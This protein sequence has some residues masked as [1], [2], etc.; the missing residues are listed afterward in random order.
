MTM[1]WTP[2]RAGQLAVP[3]PHHASR[4]ARAASW[5]MPRLRPITRRG[6]HGASGRA[7]RRVD[8]HGRHG[9]RRHDP[10]TARVTAPSARRDSRPPRKLT[11][12]IEK[13]ARRDRRAAG[14]GIRAER[15]RRPH[16]R[17]ALRSRPD[18]PSCCGAIE[19]VEITVVNHLTEAT[20]IH[21]H[22]MELDSYYDG[23]H[24]WSG[25]DRRL[26]P[27]IEPGGTFVVRFTPPR[28]GTFIYHTHLH[29]YRQLSSGLYG[30]IDRD[31]AGRD[32]RSSDR[33][34]DRARQERPRRPRSPAC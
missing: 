6:H 24:G 27:M 15:R 11:L 17:Q 28:A 29:D 13:R 30:P 7:R 26:A 2:E 23:V 25:V 18:R 32:V 16:P 34:R 19:P 33:S 12:A 8:R 21:W 5:A 31:G 9:A 14:C 4:V 3:L 1:T 10:R 22:G 20:A